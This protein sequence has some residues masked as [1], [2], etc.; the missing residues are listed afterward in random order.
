MVKDIFSKNEKVDKDAKAGEPELIP[1]GDEL[2]VLGEE[3]DP[4]GRR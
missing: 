3:D 2:V 4:K 1:E